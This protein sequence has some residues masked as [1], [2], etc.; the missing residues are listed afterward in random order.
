[1]QMEEQVRAEW[2]QVVCGLR[3]TGSDN[4]QVK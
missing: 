2:K 4:V 3:S 1:M